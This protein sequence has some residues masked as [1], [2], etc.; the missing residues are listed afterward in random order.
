METLVFIQLNRN[1]CF[2]RLL[3]CRYQRLIHLYL[4]KLH[5]WTNYKYMEVFLLIQIGLLY[6]CCFHYNQ[7]VLALPRICSVGFYFLTESD[8]LKALPSSCIGDEKGEC[9]V[10]INP[11][12]YAGKKGLEGIA[13][14]VDPSYK[15]MGIGKKLI[16]Y[17][18][19]LGFDYIWGMQY[20]SLGNIGHWLKRRKLAAVTPGLFYTI[21]DLNVNK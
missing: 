6:P 2:L 1:Q 3:Q 20:E 11:D 5:L 17:S 7:C 4:E 18:Q 19:E 14:G 21:Q 15:K 13:L 10:F 12:E 8:I 16:D 9:E